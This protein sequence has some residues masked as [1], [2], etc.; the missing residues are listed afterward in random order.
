MST[1]Y[2]PPC[3]ALHV[4]TVAA[5]TGR[6]V[7]TWQRRMEQGLVARQADGRALVPWAAL[8]AELAVPLAAQ[9]APLLER[10]DRGEAAA[11]A[12]MG[13]L[14]ALAALDAA[15]GSEGND[16]G[17]AAARYFLELAA[18]QGEAD[19]MHWLALLHAAGRAGGAEGDALALM[20]L[21]RAA[22]HGHVLAREQ[23]AGLVPPTG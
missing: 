18:Q 1:E 13:A 17:V 9:D 2:P 3:V 11:Q 4:N 8:Q 5:V 21:A 20:W 23:V 19:A 12:D 15:Q 16:G 14:L 22:A 6:S 7:R 10:A